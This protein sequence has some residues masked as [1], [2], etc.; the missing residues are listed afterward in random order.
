MHI[1]LCMTWQISV[2]FFHPGPGLG[3]LELDKSPNRLLGLTKNLKDFRPA[4]TNVQ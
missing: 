3:Y 1:E 2:I 4:L